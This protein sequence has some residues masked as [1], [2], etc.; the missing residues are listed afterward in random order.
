MLSCMASTASKVILFGYLKVTLHGDTT[1][2][3]T[4]ATRLCSLLACK[5][6]TA[7]VSVL[8]PRKEVVQHIDAGL[9]AQHNTIETSIALLDIEPA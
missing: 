6:G 8:G 1:D 9:H 2:R 7:Y 4:D 5:P 3:C